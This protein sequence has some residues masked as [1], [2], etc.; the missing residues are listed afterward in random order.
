MD[1]AEWPAERGE[2][3][4]RRLS[5][6]FPS[7]DYTNRELWR[8]YL[9][10][11]ARVD[12]DNDEQGEQIAEKSELCLKVGR[13]L[14]VDGR[15]REAVSWLQESYEWRKRKLDEDDPDLLLSQHELA[16]AY[17]ANGQVKQIVELLERVVAIR[18]EV[19]AEDHP[20]RLASQHVLAALHE[21]LPERSETNQT[22][23]RAT[24]DVAENDRAREFVQVSDVRWAKSGNS[25]AF[26]TRSDRSPAD[27]RPK[28][29]SISRRQVLKSLK[30]K[31]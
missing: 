15:M 25:S 29:S 20:H 11:V 10:H 6:V 17:R 23:D 31:E 3:G 21:D 26:A 9:P 7:D 22:S 30:G 1:S 18:E 5:E 16:I 19:L 28:S 24:G 14:R 4:G 2:K 8:E 13:C 27:K 12:G